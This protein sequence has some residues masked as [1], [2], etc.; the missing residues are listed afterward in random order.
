M[1]N[2]KIFHSNFSDSSNCNFQKQ[3]DPIPYP[4]ATSN[5]LRNYL[6][7]TYKDK[8]LEKKVVNLH[9]FFFYL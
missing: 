8:C 9:F 2:F 4:T 5:I 7:T 1:K 3:M 6:R